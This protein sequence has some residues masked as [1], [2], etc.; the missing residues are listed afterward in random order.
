M[1]GWLAEPAPMGA[2]EFVSAKAYGVAAVVTKDPALMVDDLF[3]VLQLEPGALADLENYQREH[4]LDLRYD[5]AAPL[6]NEFLV[7]LDG[8]I[9]PNPSWK[10]VIEVN[11]AARLQNAI[12]RSIAEVNRQRAAEQQPPM[13]LTSETSGG[14]TFYAATADKIP[15]EIHYTFWAGYMIIAPNRALLLEAIQHHDNGTTLARSAAFRSQFPADGRDYAS[16]FVYQ[17]I[18]ALASS[19]PVGQVQEAVDALPTL[20]CVYGSADRIVMS[21]KGVLG[22]NIAGLTGISGMMNA[23]GLDW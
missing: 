23:T 6:G 22:M 1:A 15:T 8:P 7:A 2:L 16:G 4:R 21:S 3:N 17:N 18:Q 19:L 14:R 10:V 20:V 13:R 12:E 11:D 5:V 9:L